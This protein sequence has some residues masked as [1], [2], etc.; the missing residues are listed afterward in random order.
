MRTL[1]RLSAVHQ[2]FQRHCHKCHYQAKVRVPNTPLQS[3]SGRLRRAAGLA[4]AMGGLRDI[5][6][7]RQ[8]KNSLCQTRSHS[9]GYAGDDLGLLADL[10]PM[11][12]SSC[13]ELRWQCR[14]PP[15]A[16]GPPTRHRLLRILPF[17]LMSAPP[18]LPAHPGFLTMAP[19]TVLRRRPQTAV[20]E[21]RV[22][23]CR[24]RAVAKRM[25]TRK[26][27]DAFRTQRT[28]KRH[29]TVSSACQLTNA[30]E[31]RLADQASTLKAVRWSHRFT[32][33]HTTHASSLNSKCRTT[34]SR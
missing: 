3:A 20:I 10:A 31:A 33:R 25:K 9:N 21:R 28:L 16:L 14:D 24:R 8:A 27:T 11:P 15:Q 29:G 7:H 13:R 18:R 4:S 30:G 23:P 22:D 32:Q 26:M 12:G 34:S 2:P 1:R 5:A 19:V 17:L 6:R